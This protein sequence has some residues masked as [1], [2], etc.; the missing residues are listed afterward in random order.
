MTVRLFLEF[1]VALQ[2]EALLFQKKALI[3]RAFL[4]A[5]LG[6]PLLSRYG[7]GASPDEFAAI[8]S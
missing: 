4:D 5:L 2:Q 6:E 1:F 8:Q 3:I 7:P